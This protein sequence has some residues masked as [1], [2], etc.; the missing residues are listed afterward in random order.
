MDRT[1]EMILELMKGNA[2]ISYQ[3]LGNALGISRVAARKRVNKLE[4]EGII[5]G[6]NTCIY[7]GDITF[8]YDIV[9]LP[10]KMDQVMEYL[11][12]HT[13]YIRQIFTTNRP[14]HIHMVAVSDS[15]SNLNYLS[16]MIMKKCGDM[17]EDFQVF[18]VWN[19]IKDVYGGVGYEQGNESDSDGSDE[20]PGGS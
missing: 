4:A 15:N 8:I 19:V 16:K 6:Y 13:A 7:K 11:I 20:Q 10:D 5:R 2:R 18:A 3:E 12:Y 17:I 14:N 9:T 1:D